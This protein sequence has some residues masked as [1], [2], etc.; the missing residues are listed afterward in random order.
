MVFMKTF[1]SVFCG[2]SKVRG[3]LLK[4]KRAVGSGGSGKRGEPAPRPDPLSSA[5]STQRPERNGVV[6]GDS[7]DVG[8]G[9]TEK[10]R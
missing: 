8:P 5:S 6:G 9:G 3:V 7:P 4:K 10:G 2:S 1:D